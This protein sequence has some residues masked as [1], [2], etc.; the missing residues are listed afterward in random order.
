MKLMQ[1][2]VLMM[3]A[4][5]MGVMPA[6]AAAEYR[7]GPGDTVAISVFGEQDLSPQVRVNESGSIPFPFLGELQVVGLTTGQLR[8]LL[9]QGLKGDYLIDPTIAVSVAVYRPFYVNGEVE[10]PGHFSYEP[11]MTVRKALSL[12]GGTTDRA[13]LKK[14]YLNPFVI[15]Y[16]Q[17]MLTSVMPTPIAKAFLAL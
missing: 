14:I 8:D 9:M 16:W 17:N 1:Q 4:L 13:S 5:M 15:K 6:L 11:G 7:L 10:E 3:L 2:P 12:A